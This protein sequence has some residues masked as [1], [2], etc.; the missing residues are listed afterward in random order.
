M[1]DAKMSH[2]LSVEAVRVF[3]KYDPYTE[4]SRAPLLIAKRHMMSAQELLR[5]NR[6]LKAL[7]ENSFF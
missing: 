5:C 6:T 7:R 1:S 3:R 4:A 2:V